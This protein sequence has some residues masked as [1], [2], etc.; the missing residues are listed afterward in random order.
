M[1]GRTA[2]PTVVPALGVV[3]RVALQRANWPRTK[4]LSVAVV[5]VEERVSAVKLEKHSPPRLM[6]GSL[7]LTPPS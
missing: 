3:V 4:S 7:R 6:A 2:V 1:P 5:E